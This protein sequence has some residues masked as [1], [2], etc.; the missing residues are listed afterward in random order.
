MHFNKGFVL[1]KKDNENFESSTEYCICDNTFVE[2]YIRVRNHCHVTRKYIII[3]RL[4]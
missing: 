1:T 3:S 4:N 2:V